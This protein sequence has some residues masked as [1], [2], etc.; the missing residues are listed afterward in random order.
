MV[1][2]PYRRRGLGG[3][4]DEWM[5]LSGREVDARGGCNVQ[6]IIERV[7]DLGRDCTFDLSGWY[8]D[9]LSIIFRVGVLKSSTDIVSITDFALARVRSHQRF[10][11]F[12]KDEAR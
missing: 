10:A 5:E 11:S 3:S 9:D 4:F 1:A 2:T 8:P 12:V 6:R 7:C